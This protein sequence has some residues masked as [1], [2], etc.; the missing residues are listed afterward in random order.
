MSN[1][2]GPSLKKDGNGFI[3]TLDAEGKV[4]ERHWSKGERSLDA[5]KGMGI[6]GDTLWVADID[7]L[8]GFDRRSGTPVAT[9]SLA[10][11]E[12]EFLND[13]AVGPDGAVY[14]TDTGLTADSLGNRRHGRPDRIFRVG[15]DR[16]PSVALESDRLG[17]PNGIAW[18]E[19]EARF[20]VAGFWGDTIWGWKPGSRS[21][22]PVAVGPGQV[23]GIVTTPAGVLVSSSATSALH[24][25]E[26]GKLVKVAPHLPG[27]ADIGFS[28]KSGLVA[29]PL[30]GRNRVVFYRMAALDGGG[31]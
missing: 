22:S 15:P 7:V 5:P 10:G 20:L 21:L 24:R 31:R 29:V 23:D 1:I 26:N 17:R 9:V 27:P 12:A 4:V 16:E 18:D 13:V 2:A 11:L 19:G 28:P 3:T 14:L 25:I 6:I 8:R 30:L